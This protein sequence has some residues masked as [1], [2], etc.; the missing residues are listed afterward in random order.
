VYFAT[1]VKIDNYL[2]LRKDDRSFASSALCQRIWAEIITK[3]R[4]EHGRPVNPGPYLITTLQP[5]IVP[6]NKM[7]L[8]NM[9]TT[10]VLF[11]W[12]IY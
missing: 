6:K 5:A 2:R 4:S 12:Y 9:H 1:L 3:L 10:C 8:C 11:I 7:I